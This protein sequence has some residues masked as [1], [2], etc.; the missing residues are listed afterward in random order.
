[1][2][3]VRFKSL[4][5]FRG[6]TVCI[7]IIVNTSGAGAEPFATLQH[8]KW[9]GFTLADAVFPSFLFAVG[10]AMSFAMK[11][12]VSNRD[13]L[14]KVLKR[15]ALIFLLGFLMYWYP[16]VHQQDNGAW[17][18]NALGETRIMGVL[19]RIALCFGIAAIA[20]RYLSIKYLVALCVLLLGGYWAILMAF[21][22]PGQ[23]L[24]PLGN[25]G[26]LVDQAV[27]GLPHMYRKGH[28]YDPEGL[29]STLP[30]IVNVIAGFLAGR[31]ISA[32]TDK[33]KL[34]RQLVITGVAAIAAGLLW[35]LGFPLAKRIWTSSFVVLTIGIDLVILG[36]L[37]TYVEIWGQTR[38]TWFFEIFGKNPL[39]IYLFSELFV[40]TLQLIKINGQGAYDW[41]GIHLFQVVLPGAIGSLVC[42]V[43]YMLVCWLL[44]YAMDRKNLIIKL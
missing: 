43:A 30:A 28:G 7:M 5:V 23:Q 8:A 11:P 41:V 6:L 38:G 17:A 27:L 36:A 35:S 31:F 15:T 40:T 33:P 19:Q 22:L 9:F 4:D 10:N 26:A 14:L 24:T 16:F 1:M 29:L 25:A 3:P 12:G 20:C 18:L 21:G 32:S 13:Y 42:A 37:I 44:G 2:K 39:V 34:V